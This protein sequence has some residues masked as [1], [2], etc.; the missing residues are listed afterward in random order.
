MN[1]L[2]HTGMDSLGLHIVFVIKLFNLIFPKT[3]FN[4]LRATSGQL[5]LN[6]K[7]ILS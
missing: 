6:S 3:D 4:V 5:S 2:D 7:N 1:M